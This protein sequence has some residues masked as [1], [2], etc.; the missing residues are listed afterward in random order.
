MCELV[1]RPATLS[2]RRILPMSD[3]R[4]SDFLAYILGGFVIAIGGIAVG[5][6]ST[7]AVPNSAQISGQ[8]A[9]APHASKAPAA[10]NF[11]PAS[12]TRSQE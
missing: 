5:V 4:E 11:M 12:S 2:H 1:R 10:P 8:A 9:A 7:N 3:K 6:A